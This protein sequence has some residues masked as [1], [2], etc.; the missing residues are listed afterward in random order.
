MAFG[1]CE[2]NPCWNRVAWSIINVVLLS[3]RDFLTLRSFILHRSPVHPSTGHLLD[4]LHLVLLLFPFAPVPSPFLPC[5][6]KV[7]L[8][9]FLIGASDG[10]YFSYSHSWNF[11][12]FAW[13]PEVRGGKGADVDVVVG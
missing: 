4:F 6:L 1:G 7:E 9:M 13:E 3:V 8:A 10:C 12:S 2:R 5:S 11:D